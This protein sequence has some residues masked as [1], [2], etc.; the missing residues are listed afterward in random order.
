ML[1][2]EHVTKTYGGARKGL[3]GLLGT[4][5]AEVR[6]L[7]DVS[8]SVRRGESFGLV[9][10]SGSGK[11]TLTRCILRLEEVSA[12]RILFDGTD[13]ATL[14]P[15]EMRSLRARVQIVFQ[16]PYA[17]L[18][19]RMSVCDILC[20]PMEIHRDRMGL[21]GR[22]RLDRAAELLQRVGLGTQ[23]LSRFPHEFSGGQRQRIGI[24]RALATKPD[25]LILDEPTS[26]LDVSVQA[27]VLNLLHELQAQL[28]LTY[29]F[30]S[31]DLGVIRYI[32]DRVALIYRGQLVE[33][34]DTETVFR[35]PASDYAR[36]LLAAMPD[37]DPDRSPFHASSHA[38]RPAP[39]PGQP[40]A[41]SP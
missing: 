1:R 13:L 29:F 2:I 38:A 34:G 27:Q 21:D 3:A 35:S 17:S 39:G 40:P 37:P 18:N 30:I 16:D 9:G 32:C 36:M 6:A 19:P 28:G 22:G 4:A 10:E 20:E 41:A 12:G 7:R 5:A 8:L 31:H 24:A 14:K 25:F 33:E 11:T 15:A 26:A 23:H